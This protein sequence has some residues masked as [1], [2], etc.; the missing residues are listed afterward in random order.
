MATLVR[1]LMFRF[2][3]VKIV[4]VIVVIFLFA[5]FGKCVNEANRGIVNRLTKAVK[6]KSELRNGATQRLSTAIRGPFMGIALLNEPFSI[7][8]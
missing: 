1:W 7:E 6:I 3:D 4:I 8:V 5:I 2:I